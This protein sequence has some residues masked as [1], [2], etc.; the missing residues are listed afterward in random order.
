M[1]E[2][3]KH[4]TILILILLRTQPILYQ[5]IRFKLVFESAFTGRA[6][7]EAEDAGRQVVSPGLSRGI[8]AVQHNPAF[9]L[10][11][12]LTLLYLYG[13]SDWSQYRSD[14]HTVLSFDVLQNWRRL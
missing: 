4:R 6:S 12:Y 7:A 10:E 13:T 8:D 9:D 11:C 3:R 2:I 14:K 1:F 5:F